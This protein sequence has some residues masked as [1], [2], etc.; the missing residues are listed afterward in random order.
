MN[1]IIAWSVILTF[2]AVT[3]AFGVALLPDKSVRLKVAFGLF[4]SGLIGCFLGFMLIV[5]RR[6]LGESIDLTQA[7]L[8]RRDASVYTSVIPIGYACLLV[9]VL[10]TSLQ[11]LTAAI[12]KLKRL[13]D[14]LRKRP[15]GKST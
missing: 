3:W 4:L 6:S 7:F 1:V 9:S 11:S 12:K 5:V 15:P 10:E 2:A 13:A 8:I 14:I